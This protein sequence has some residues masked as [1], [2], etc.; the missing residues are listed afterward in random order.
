MLPAIALPRSGLA[1]GVVELRALNEQD[2]PAF[3]DALRDPAIGDGAYHGKVPAELDPA[4][5]YVGSNATR[6]ASGTAVLLAVWEPGADRLS[7]QTML[8]NVDRD[9]LTAE[10]G[11]WT[12][13]WA[14]RKG[15]SVAALRL[16]LALAFERLGLERVYGLTGVENAAAQRAMERVGLHREGILRGLERT[17]DGRLD[18]VSYSILST[19]PRP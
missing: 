14:R 6:M 4:R 10:L 2:T 13:P 12:A 8:F 11:F 3:V 15:L 5:S 7:G 16:T 1:D 17:P 9:E 18:Q 19:D